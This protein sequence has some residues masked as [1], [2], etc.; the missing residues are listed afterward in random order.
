VAVQY[1]GGNHAAVVLRASLFQDGRLVSQD[2]H[3]AW[4]GYDTWRNL[5]NLVVPSLQQ[6]SVYTLEVE[7]RS[8]GGD[9]SRG[10]IHLIRGSQ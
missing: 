5:Y 4:T 7:L 3:R 9:Q 2:Q 6:G 8:D 1:T 10:E